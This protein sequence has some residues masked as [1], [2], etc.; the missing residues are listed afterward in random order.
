MP[1]GSGRY[2]HQSL[3]CL[4]SGENVNPNTATLL[5]SARRI[6]RVNPQAFWY[7]A[8][9]IF[10]FKDLLTITGKAYAVSDCFGGSE[11]DCNEQL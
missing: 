1:D 6:G 4:L 8:Y 3:A 7:P 5:A 2:P 9:V 10:D 11:R